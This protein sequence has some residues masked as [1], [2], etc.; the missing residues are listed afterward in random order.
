MLLTWQ[1]EGLTEG[2]GARNPAH[3]QNTRYIAIVCGCVCVREESGWV[4]EGGGREL[5]LGVAEGGGL[6]YKSHH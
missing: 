6:D 5:P 4:E 1:A 3:A 2:Y